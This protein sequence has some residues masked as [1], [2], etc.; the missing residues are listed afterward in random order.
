MTGVA[1]LC[2]E[3]TTQ[4]SADGGQP[5][6]GGDDRSI[7]L[8]IPPGQYVFAGLDTAPGET[9][10]EVGVQP[11]A[12]GRVLADAPS[13]W[14]LHVT[15]PESKNTSDGKMWKPVV[16]FVTHRED[17]SARQYA[18]FSIVDYAPP[19]SDDV[20]L[21]AEDISGKQDK[22]KLLKV[23]YGVTNG[24]SRSVV[25]AIADDPE[26]ISKHF[27]IQSK[28]VLFDWKRWLEVN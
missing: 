18:I 23:S 1:G 5:D 13:A 12:M 4:I 19:S 24:V 3:P 26:A 28:Y 27:K 14:T 15:V 21:R 10:E 6:N 22:L 2:A 16:A 20:R 7:T 9:L 17:G 25:V 8:P 11:I